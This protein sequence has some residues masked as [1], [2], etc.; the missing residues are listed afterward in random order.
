[1]NDPLTSIRLP[2]N[3]EVLGD[4]A[5]LDMGA[6]KD[7]WKLPRDF[8]HGCTSLTSITLP[9]NV[10]VIRAFSTAAPAWSHWSWAL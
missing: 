10:E 5:S 2:P 9:P 7:V 1:M 4:G 6:L 8:M 3:V